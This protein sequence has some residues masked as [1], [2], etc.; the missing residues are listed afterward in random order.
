MKCE[1]ML[2]IGSH[3]LKNRQPSGQEEVSQCRII[4]KLQELIDI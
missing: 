4:I 2:A 3:E 1:L